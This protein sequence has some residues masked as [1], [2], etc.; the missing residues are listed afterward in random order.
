[1]A[2]IMQIT[3]PMQ[4]ADVIPRYPVMPACFNRIVAN[5]RVAIAIPDTGLFDEPTT[6]T[7]LADTV[8]KKNPKIMIR[9]DVTGLIGIS[10]N[11]LRPNATIRIPP[12]A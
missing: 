2:A 5:S 7:I 9:M 4:M 1:M 12:I 8:A 11:A 10:G 6:P 3:V